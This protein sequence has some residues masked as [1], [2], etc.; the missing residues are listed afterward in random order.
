VRTNGDGFAREGTGLSNTR[1]RLRE[2]FGADHA[3][4]VAGAEGGGVEVTL[5]LPVR[6]AAGAARP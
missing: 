6:R 5:D 3:V 4:R 1:L 2:M